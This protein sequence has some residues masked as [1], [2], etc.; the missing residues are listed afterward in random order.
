MS[1]E[2]RELDIQVSEK[3]MKIE[4]RLDWHVMNADETASCLPCETSREAQEWLDARPA[5]KDRYHVG[6]WKRYPPYSSDISAAMQVVERMAGLGWQIEVTNP[7]KLH[8]PLTDNV[9]VW[10]VRFVNDENDLNSWSD[11]RDSLPEAICR[12]AIEALE[13]QHQ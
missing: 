5:L 11:E 7:H 12:A 10:Y 2:L 8:E 1:D 3:V 9:R 6:A 13:D 4:P